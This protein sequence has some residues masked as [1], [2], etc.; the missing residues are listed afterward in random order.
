MI[1]PASAAITIVI[2]F[3]GAL[4]A[5]LFQRLFGK[6]QRKQELTQRYIDE[7][8]GPNFFTHVISASNVRRQFLESNEPEMF[9]QNLAAGFWFPGAKPYF[10]GATTNGLNDHEHIELAIRFSSRLSNA[11]R[12][13]MVDQRRIKD[14]LADDYHWTYSLLKEISVEVER[15]RGIAEQKGRATEAKW[16]SDIEFLGDFFQYKTSLS[17]EK[18]EISQFR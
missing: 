15:Q 5:Y 2:S 16:V 17:S 3:V 1:D 6:E 10:F 12:H 18:L 14:A 11:I 4:F 7:L 9:I 8:L 13:N